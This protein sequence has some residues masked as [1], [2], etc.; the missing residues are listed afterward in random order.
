MTSSALSVRHGGTLLDLLRA[1]TPTPADRVAFEAR[2]RSSLTHRALVAH[3]L[4]VAN[5]LADRGLTSHDTVALVMPDGPDLATAFLGVSARSVAAPFNPRLQAAEFAFYLTDLNAAAVLLDASDSPVRDVARRLGIAVLEVSPREPAG[6]FE[7]SGDEIRATAA[8]RDPSPDDVAL[9]LHTSGTTARPK[10]VPLTHRNIT[11][12]ALHVARA[13]AL[14]TDD[15]SLA[16]MPLF[17]VHGL[18][19]AM[20]APLAAGGTVVCTPGASGGA[21]VLEGLASSRATWYTAVPSM[22]QAILAGAIATGR[23]ASSLRLIRSASAPLPPHVQEA[24]EQTF[25]VPVIEA[26]GMTEAAH[27]I[28]S[29]PLPPRP[30]KPGSVGVAS[31]PAVTILDESGLQLAPGMKGEIAIRGTNVVAGYA[32]N[33]DANARA[34]S[35]G[36]FRTGDQ[37]WIDDDGFIFISG[38]LKEL[39]N[40]AGEKIAPREVDEILA[41]HPD[42]AQAA[43]FAVP[44]ERVGEDIEAAIVLR[45]GALVS[46][47]DLRH[48]AAER[49]ALFKVPRRIHFVGDIPKGPTGKIQRVG[50]AAS[51]G[52]TPGQAVTRG[53]QP[54]LEP[55]LLEAKLAALCAEVLDVEQVGVDDDFLQIGGD[56]LLATQFVAR[57]IEALGVD[58]SVVDFLAPDGTTVANFARAIASRQPRVSGAGDATRPWGVRG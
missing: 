53:E 33:D 34:F 14:S 47:R 46:E 38:R 7:L 12:S 6:F 43:T 24:M 30:R 42:V 16:V 36:W 56:S 35:N 11:A 10:V 29:N 44:D 55:T 9:V 5:A 39:I 48:F 45:Q 52:I 22:H 51:L 27:Q 57:V 58:V 50:L 21:R 4:S 2:G 40:R 23:V 13:L 17:H 37:G 32:G 49:L 28:A 26:Y 20:L 3:V 54:S 8:R 15:R 31:G 41:E 19:A 18:V 1:A 25:G